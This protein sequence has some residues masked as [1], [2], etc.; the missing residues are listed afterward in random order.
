M[1][2]DAVLELEVTQV[3]RNEAKQKLSMLEKEIEDFQEYNDMSSSANKR[4]LNKKNE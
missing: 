1:L 4:E 2:F 3:A